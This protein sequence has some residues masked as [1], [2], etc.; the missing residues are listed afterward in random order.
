MEE[1]YYKQFFSLLEKLLQTTVPENEKKRLM[2]CTRFRKL[3]KKE[4][5]LSQ[6][7]IPTDFIFAISGLLRNY[8]IDGNGN[9]IT[10]DFCFEGEGLNYTGFV[11][12]APSRVYIEAL[13]ETV[14]LLIEYES[15]EKLME[16]N[17][18]WLTQVRRIIE[19][20]LFEKDI[21]ESSFILNSAT[22]RYL[23]LLK[24]RPGVEQRINQVYLASYLGI[25]PVSLS[26]IRNK[27]GKINIC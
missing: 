14:I 2:E 13:E 20:F 5:Y 26:R 16:N 23:Y 12:K 24:K 15:L 6:G 22:E 25:T 27:L 18:F 21:R 4:V 11:I 19:Y 1:V 10:K 8:Y 17:V 9:D 7:E 3:Q